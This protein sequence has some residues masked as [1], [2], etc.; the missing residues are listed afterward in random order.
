METNIKNLSWL[1]RTEYPFE[2]KYIKLSSGRLQYIDEG[3]GHVILF[4][5]G[6]PTW[7]FLYRNY[8]KELSKNYRCIAIDNLGFGLSDN[9]VGFD[10]TPQ[11]HS[12]N[13]IEF[14]EQLDLKNI[15]LVVH[16]FGGPIGLSA[17]ITLHNRISKI[18]MFNTWLWETKSRKVIVEIDKIINS[19]IGKFM[20]FNMNYSAK[21]LLK[22][23]FYKKSLLSKHIHRQYIGPFLESKSRNSAYNL[24]KSLLGSSDWSQKQWDN[25]GAIS[26]KKWLIIWG[27]KDTFL[28]MD[29]LGKWEKRLPNAKVV[30]LE[31]GHFVQEEEFSKS[32]VEMERFLND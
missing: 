21:S 25:L 18:I 30:E 8:I 10:G 20:Y 6:T 7:S 11:S 14:I 29:Y 17:A 27:T 13:L 9:Q 12:N 4:I 28:T 16:D 31:C 3:K 15:S 5:H 22:K 26:D 19:F 24:A 32:L 1:D 23:G 2:N